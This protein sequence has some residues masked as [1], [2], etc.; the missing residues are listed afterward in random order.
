MYSLAFSNRKCIMSQIGYVFRYHE[1][2]SSA[3]T[4]R[5]RPSE[6]L[7]SELGMHTR[8][9][10]TG[11]RPAERPHVAAR[12]GPHPSHSSGVSVS[13]CLVKTASGGRYHNTSK[14]V[15]QG[16]YMSSKDK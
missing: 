10:A 14:D 3:R 8:E 2:I 11:L 4:G 13:S 7:L 9:R 15:W 5:P 12:N 1:F 6:D 16:L